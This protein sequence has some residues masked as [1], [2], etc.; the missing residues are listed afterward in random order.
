MGLTNFCLFHGE[1]PQWKSNFVGDPGSSLI[2][3]LS[4]SMLLWLVVS[5]ILKNM[6]VNGKDYPIYYGKKTVPNHQPVLDLSN[7]NICVG[8]NLAIFTGENAV[9][10]HFNGGYPIFRPQKSQANPPNP[11]RSKLRIWS[12]Q[13]EQFRSHC[14]RGVSRLAPA[15]DGVQ[16]YPPETRH[17]W[18]ENPK[19]IDD[20]QSYQLAFEGN[21]PWKPS[22]FLLKSAL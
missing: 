19:N 1:S 12:A 2:Y 22:I 3:S 17:G 11:N 21:F 4:L 16:W 5:T 7:Q 14:P 20:F 6:K 10:I 13:N 15:K 8:D 9:P 18:L